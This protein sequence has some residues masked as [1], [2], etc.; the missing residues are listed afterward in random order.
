M[1]FCE[2]SDVK[3][4][5]NT[6][7]KNVG[8]MNSMAEAFERSKP[9]A[10]DLTCLE[11]LVHLNSICVGTPEYMMIDG[12]LDEV[13]ELTVRWVDG[14][15]SKLMCDRKSLE[16]IKDGLKEIVN[17]SEKYNGLGIRRNLIQ[18]A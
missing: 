8:Q 5:S 4:F 2:T 10:I 11:V 9:T 7:M 3:T 16:C 17:W 18:E 15:T 13:H 1:S 14:S 12:Y 6:F